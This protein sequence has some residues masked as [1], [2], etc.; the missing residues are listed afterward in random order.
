MKYLYEQ[1]VELAKKKDFYDGINDEK[2]ATYK[3]RARYIIL[4]ERI[5]K[6]YE[7]AKNKSFS[8]YIKE[9][10]WQNKKRLELVDK[11]GYVVHIEA[12]YKDYKQ[13]E[14]ENEKY[15]VNTS[16][17]DFIF[18]WLFAN[19]EKWEIEEVYNK[20]NVDKVDFRD[21]FLG[22]AKEKTPSHKWHF[23]EVLLYTEINNKVPFTMVK[24]NITEP[25]LIKWI[26]DNEV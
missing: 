17:D 12:D 26:S 19:N 24:G 16:W 14:I 6:Y 21:W 23:F 18:I 15:L 11:N 8:D 3:E 20:N 4:A 25:E 7:K 9:I 5:S 22:Q 13:I 2:K 10:D 1:S